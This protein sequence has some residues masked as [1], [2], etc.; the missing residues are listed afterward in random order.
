MRV[1][2]AEPGKPAE[3]REVED[4]LDTFQGLVGGGYIEVLPGA[5]LGSFDVVIN[6]EGLLVELP[7][8]RMIATYL[9]RDEAAAYA[10]VGP[11]FV[12]KADGEGGWV[13]LTEDEAAAIVEALNDPEV[14]VCRPLRDEEVPEPG[15]TI[16]DWEP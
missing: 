3:V 8:N 1:V 12:T 14:G 2:V 7:P 15:F 9:S 5:F 13:S 11:L 6:D 10:V 16:T 4:S